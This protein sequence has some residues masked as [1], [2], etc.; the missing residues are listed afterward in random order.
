MIPAG[1][2][3]AFQPSTEGTPRENPV[4]EKH[5]CPGTFTLIISDTQL[6][7]STINANRLVR[8]A[9]A[10]NQFIGFN[11]ITPGTKVLKPARYHIDGKM[12]EAQ[13]SFLIPKRRGDTS[14]EPRFWPYKLGKYVNGGDKIFIQGTNSTLIV[15][16]SEKNLET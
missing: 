14:P 7:K 3:R 8:D 10:E 6:R 11:E 12:V 15:T 13:A 5:W 2:R 9:F 1:D 16:D 4:Y